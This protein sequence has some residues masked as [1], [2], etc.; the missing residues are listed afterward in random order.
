MI[1]RK[2]REVRESHVVCP[3]PLLCPKASN[4]KSQLLNPGLQRYFFFQFERCS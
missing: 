3:R 4:L 2:W 1:G